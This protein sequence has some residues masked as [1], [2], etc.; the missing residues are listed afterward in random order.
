MRE[1]QQDPKVVRRQNRARRHIKGLIF[2][3]HDFDWKSAPVLED[4]TKVRPADLR[5]RTDPH[6]HDSRSYLNEMRSQGSPRKMD[7]EVI[8]VG[9]GGD[10]FIDGEEFV[11]MIG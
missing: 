11:D 8:A 5:H 4:H 2:D 3:Q 1:T 10:L 6:Y 9:D 7:F